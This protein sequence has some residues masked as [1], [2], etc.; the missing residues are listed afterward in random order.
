M[1]NIT[2][3]HI[4]AG[5]SCGTLVLWYSV[6]CT[7]YSTNVYVWYYTVYVYHMVHWCVGTMYTNYAYQLHIVPMYHSTNAPMSQC[8]TM[9]G[10]YMLNIV[11]MHD[12]KYDNVPLKCICNEY[13]CYCEEHFEIGTLVHWNIYEQRR[14]PVIP[15]SNTLYIGR[16]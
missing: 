8:T 5:V 13:K 9:V 10:C 15:T 12:L 7:L 16:E 2:Y 4:I 1:I 6:H 14:I 11:P 3:L